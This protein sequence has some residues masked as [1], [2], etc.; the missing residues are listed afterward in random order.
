MLKIERI[1]LETKTII[2]V[3][4]WWWDGGRERERERERER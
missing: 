4:L 1:T 3:K 2:E